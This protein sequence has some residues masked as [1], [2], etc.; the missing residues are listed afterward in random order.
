[1]GLL[2]RRFCLAQAG[3]T[4]RRE[5][6]AGLTTFATLSYILFFQTHL[7]MQ[8]LEQ[9]VNFHWY[10]D[11]KIPRWLVYY[12]V[13]N[14]VSQWRNDLDIWENKVHVAKPLL[15]KGDGPIHRVRKWFRQFYPEP[16]DLDADDTALAAE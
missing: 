5:V 16:T 15:V 6:L 8:P 14:W 10:A 1:M 11:A 3:T 13:G 7:P 4:A 9:Q 2:E 12:V